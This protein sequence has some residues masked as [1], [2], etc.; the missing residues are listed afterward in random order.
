MNLRKEGV[1]SAK[2]CIFTERKGVLTPRAQKQ[3]SSR[4]QRLGK[5]R[6]FPS[7]EA[8]K[9]AEKRIHFL[10]MSAITSL[11]SA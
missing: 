3:F 5:R 4:M 9:M 11:I 8:S 7:V 6:T 1:L 2:R 10:F